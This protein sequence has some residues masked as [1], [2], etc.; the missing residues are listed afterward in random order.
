MRLS[1]NNNCIRLQIKNELNTL[2]RIFLKIFCAGLKFLPL[3]ASFVVAADAVGAAGAVEY[4]DEAVGAV[5]RAQYFVFWGQYK[6]TVAVDAA[7]PTVAPY[8]YLSPM[9]AK[10]Q[11]LYAPHRLALN[12]NNKQRQY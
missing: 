3:G 1:F 6:S 4:D 2:L 12:L 11:I 10:S 8:D 5:V 9:T 7:T